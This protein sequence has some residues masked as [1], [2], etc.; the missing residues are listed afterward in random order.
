M[1]SSGK[2]V[3]IHEN[4]QIISN[5]APQN[6]VPK[7]IKMAFM[8]CWWM[9]L[10]PALCSVYLNS[11]LNSLPDSGLCQWTKSTTKQE[12]FRELE[13]TVFI[14]LGNQLGVGNSVTK[15][16]KVGNWK[17]NKL[18]NQYKICAL[19]SLSTLLLLMADLSLA[20]RVNVSL[21]GKEN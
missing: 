14:P 13:D 4:K 12:T 17:I 3:S 2:K 1:A 8:C 15:H 21:L 10:G 5:G 6:E 19:C 18:A 7:F 11:A 20:T 16:G 9:E